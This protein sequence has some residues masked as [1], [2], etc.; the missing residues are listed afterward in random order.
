MELTSKISW[1]LNLNAL[2]NLVGT[3]SIILG[4]T[5]S[6]EMNREIIPKDLFQNSH[7]L[8]RQSGYPTDKELE[9]V[10]TKSEYKDQFENLICIGGGATID[11]G[12][13]MLSKVT[14][15]GVLL[16]I[17]NLYLIPTNVGSGAEVTNFSTLWNYESKLK[18][19]ILLPGQINKQVYYL[20][21]PLTS[22]N[23]EQLLIGTLDALSHSFDSLF[24]KMSTQLSRSTAIQ[25]IDSICKVLNLFLDNKLELK[26]YVFDLQEY[27]YI[28]GSCIGIT[29]TS[30]SHAF[31]Y[32][33][34]LEFGLVHGY[35]VAL[36]MQVVIEIFKNSLVEI[37]PESF[38]AVESIELTLKK[39]R[40]KEKVFDLNSLESKE[41]SKLIH[42]VDR[43]RLDNFILKVEE[44]TY[45]EFFLATQK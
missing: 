41:I 13:L 16:K 32:G 31:S 36:M 24:S 8:I 30:V 26:D 35:A 34:T 37:I 6:I 12:K 33:L 22:L 10:L 43:V 38:A 27:S 21:K 14:N 45:E 15:H 9:K 39:A 25:N 18:T 1:S 17:P 7:I 40:L 44:D 19:S 23:N 20:E 29:K 28:A 4:T 11:F 42:E 5:N 2:N 3:K